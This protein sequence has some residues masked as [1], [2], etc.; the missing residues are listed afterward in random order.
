MPRGAMRVVESQ[1][2]RKRRSRSSLCEDV[3]V[4]VVCVDARD[5]GCPEGVLSR[6]ERLER[7]AVLWAEILAS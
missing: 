4:E 5:S 2:R 6:E 1:G 3:V 7:L